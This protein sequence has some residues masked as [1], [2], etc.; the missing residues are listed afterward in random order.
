MVLKIIS[1]ALVTVSEKLFGVREDV[2]HGQ[3]IEL[4][5]NNVKKKLP[6]H[7]NGMPT[8]DFTLAGQI[9]RNERNSTAQPGEPG[10][11]EVFVDSLDASNDW[12]FAEVFKCAFPTSFGTTSSMNF[13]VMRF[14]SYLQINSCVR[15]SKSE[16]RCNQLRCSRF[17]RL[18]G[19]I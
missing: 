13:I 19:V 7:K 16:Q 3:R 2:N 11:A 8:R 12:V 10:L 5:E 1:R 18:F 17:S 6:D 15:F 9:L 4:M 14:V